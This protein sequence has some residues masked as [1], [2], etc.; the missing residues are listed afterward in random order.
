MRSKGFTLLEVLLVLIIIAA[1]LVPLLQ[2]FSSG[3]MASSEVKDTN[4]AAVLA[5]KKIEEIKD[6]AFASV[7]S[8]AKTTISSYP[9][10]SSQVI[11]STPQNNLKDVQ[12]I[13][14]WRPGTG[15][16][17][18]VSIETLISNF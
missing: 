8:E 4:T 3:L 2:A 14:F 15:G 12:V 1:V 10:Y 9:A 13:V 18:S 17:T 6:T 11:V 5:Q 7:S 16:E